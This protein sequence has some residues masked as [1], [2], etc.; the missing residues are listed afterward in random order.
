MV[1]DICK[2]CGK[3]MYVFSKLASTWYLCTNNN[4]KHEGLLKVN[5]NNNI[6]TPKG[7]NLQNAAM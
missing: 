6:Q 4:C 7:Y 5:L 1:N 2:E 3:K